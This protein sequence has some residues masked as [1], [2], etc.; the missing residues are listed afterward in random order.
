MNIKKA[1][2]NI[3]YCGEVVAPRRNYTVFRS[4]R[5]YL[6]LSKKSNSLVQGDFVAIKSD[7]VE[8]LAKRL[9]GQTKLTTSV[10]LERTRSGQYF[11]TRFDVL[12]VLYVLLALKRA[13]IDRRFKRRALYF[14]VKG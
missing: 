8:R 3:E 10:I 13:R 14:N 2:A 5:Q 4:N 6:L 11:K 12:N 1:F 7:A 9:R